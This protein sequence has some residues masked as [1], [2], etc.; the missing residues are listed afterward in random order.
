M[1]WTEAEIQALKAQE[2]K[3]LAVEF[4]QML[5]AK[6]KGPISPG[7]VQ[8]KELDFNLRL[9]EAEI[10]DRRRHELHEKRIK[11]LELQIQQEKTR[12]AEAEE[13]ANQVR[14]SHARVIERVAEA[15][16]S[17]STQ[18]ECA[19]RTHNLKLE[20]LASSFAAKEDNCCAS[21]E[22]WSNR[23]MRCGRK[24]ARSPISAAKLWKSVTCVRKSSGAK[25]RRMRTRRRG[26][27]GCL[28]RV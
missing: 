18:L 3:D 2:A 6:E 22:N 26:G 23:A 25:K 4:F 13:M 10:E 14:Q 24:L 8:L 28:R 1:K 17:L 19:T 16:E 12:A 15:T 9:R 7:E 21:C 27:A 5:E 20:Q 11:E